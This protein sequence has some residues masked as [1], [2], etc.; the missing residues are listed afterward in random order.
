MIIKNFHLFERGNKEQI[1]ENEIPVLNIDDVELSENNDK[2][3]SKE[4]PFKD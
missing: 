1:N 4:R 2:Q 3:I